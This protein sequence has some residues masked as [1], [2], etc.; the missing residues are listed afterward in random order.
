MVTFL[1]LYSLGN[2]SLTFNLMLI[3]THTVLGTFSFHAQKNNLL[4]LYR[5]DYPSNF[6]LVFIR[7]SD[8]WKICAPAWYVSFDVLGSFQ[9]PPLPVFEGLYFGMW[10]AFWKG[11]FG[12][13]RYSMLRW[14]RWGP[15]GANQYNDNSINNQTRIDPAFHWPKH[16]KVHVNKGSV[17]S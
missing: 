3:N 8:L 4:N 17:E 7:W 15:A 6:L 1:A 9:F 10:R 11:R 16:C 13:V 2:Q 5:T 12:R 14:L